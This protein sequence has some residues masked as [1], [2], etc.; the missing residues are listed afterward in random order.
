MLHAG[1]ALHVAFRCRESCIVEHG[2]DGNDGMQAEDIL[3]RFKHNALSLPFVELDHLVL[4]LDSMLNSLETTYTQCF[5]WQWEG[6]P[7]M[8]ACIPSSCVCCGHV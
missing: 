8:F 2:N 3:Y 1:N 7:A 6:T 4:V 5:R